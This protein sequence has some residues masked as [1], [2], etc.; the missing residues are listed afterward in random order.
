MTS[1]DFPNNIKSSREDGKGTSLDTL[2]QASKS[3]PQQTYGGK[4]MAD[5][6]QNTTKYV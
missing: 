6:G 1:N 2:I 3:Q 5:P 4:K